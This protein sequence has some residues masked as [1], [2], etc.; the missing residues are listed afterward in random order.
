MMI[1]IVLLLIGFVILVY[2][3]SMM[4]DGASSLAK[5]LDIPVIV[6][7][8]TIVAFGTSAPELFVNV[9]ASMQGRTEITLGNVIGSNLF[10][11]LVI[12]G[13]SSI[14]TPLAVKR[15]TTWIEIPLSLA[16]ALLVWICVNDA[17]LDN[18]NFSEISR[19]DG[20]VFLFFFT[21]FMVYNYY[22]SKKGDEQSDF[23]IGEYTLLRSIVMI[24]A[25][26]AGLAGGGHLIVESSVE[27]ARLA[28]LTERVIGLTI[29][30]VGTSLPELATSVV[31]ARKGNVDLA[32]GNVVGSN[33]FNIFFILGI[34]A[35]IHPVPL[36][37]GA[38]GDILIN[39]LA[40]IFLFLFIFTGKGRHIE[41][42]EGIFLLC[43]YVSY[44]GYVLYAM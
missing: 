4:V 14:I 1:S 19:I 12:V 44:M 38:S 15:N 9:F 36:N 18:R 7:G 24:I 8:L 17:V 11:V 25:G 41:R 42:F 33:I 13:I 43:I 23:E 27:L 32:I 2:G 40:G 29:V 10:N 20:I 5:R 31:A 21:I 39:I 37:S 35:V 34:S 30:S 3:A 28:G 26:F 6:I 22:L 16:A